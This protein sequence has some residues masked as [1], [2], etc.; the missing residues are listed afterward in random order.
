MSATLSIAYLLLLVVLAGYGVHRLWFVLR[1]R[2]WG[3]PAT[4]AP[5]PD[6]PYVTVQLPIYNERTV[7]ERLIRAAGRLE[8]PRERFEIQVLDD[9]TDETRAIVDREVA[10]LVD[11][12]IDA[13]VLRR[14][15]RTGYKAGA[16]EAGLAVARGEFVAIFDADFM[17]EPRFLR[18]LLPSFA[19]PAVAMV[20]A[21]WGHENRSDG[22]LTRAQAT[23]L[24]GHFALEHRVRHT[25]QLYFNFNGTAGLWRRGAISAAGGWQHDTLTEDLDLSYRAQLCGWRFDYR[26]E[27]E[28]KA[29]LPPD[30]LAF[31]SQQHRWAKGS[32]QVARKLMWR[33]WRAPVPLRNKLEATAHL[34]GNIGYPLVLLLVLCLPAALPVLDALPWWAHTGL[35]CVSTLS[36]AI[37]YGVGQAAVG[38]PP[39]QRWLDVP[40]AIALGI[41]M[42]VAQTIAVLEGWFGD[43]GTFVRTPKRGNAATSRTYRALLR[44]L[45]GL[46]LLPAA[47]IAFALWRAIDQRLW[48][49]LPFLALFLWG[50]TWVGLLSIVET[51]RARGLRAPS[52]VSKPSFAA[53][54]AGELTGELVSET[55][56]AATSRAATS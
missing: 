14:A 38:R 27:I 28:A 43:T 47:W 11:A 15:D 10:A 40:A 3:E 25:Q 4:P 18:Q 5:D 32:V 9:S 23:L 29:E 37:F 33:I 49:T 19:D 36:I 45:P 20:Q 7:V 44:G 52:G 8:H 46:E 42:S 35:F 1:F 30:I 2:P 12:G 31:K 48:G 26:P 22:L 51:L 54:I 13:K 53:G 39:A 41:G 50:F 56:E 55:A 21:R 34:T 6:A 16:L 24:D 17:P